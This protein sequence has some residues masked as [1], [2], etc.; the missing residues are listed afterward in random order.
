MKKAFSIL[1]FG[2][3]LVQ[4]SP[5]IIDISGKVTT[6]GDD[7]LKGVAVSLAKEPT[8]I[9]TTDSLGYFSI[10]TVNEMYLKDE[11]PN[12]NIDRNSMLAGQV[13]I[14]VDTLI[15]K[16]TGF[17]DKKTPI[18]SYVVSNINIVMDSAVVRVFQKNLQ[19]VTPLE[20]TLKGK[21]VVFSQALGRI[22]GNVD[23]FSGNGRKMATISFTNLEPVTQSVTLP[24][25]SPGLN[26]LRVTIRNNT[27]RASSIIQRRK[28]EY[29]QL[30]RN[31]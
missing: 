22:D 2:I 25:L 21:N 10:K 28:M 5:N 15:A 1:L 23:V 12:A 6:T 3:W 24:A 17:A 13:I 9:D 19:Q 8:I 14:A 4:A 27:S 18:E 7:P 16:K 31:K 11:I 20:F 30:I 26:I 29:L